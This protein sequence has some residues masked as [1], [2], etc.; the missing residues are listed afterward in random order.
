MSIKHYNLP[1]RKPLKSTDLN[2]L[3]NNGNELAETTSSGNEFQTVTIRT[4][5]KC[6]LQFTLES[7]KN[8]LK[9][10]PRVARLWSYEQLWKIIGRQQKRDRGK[11][12]ILFIYIFMSS[13]CVFLSF[14]FPSLFLFYLFSLIFQFLF[15]KLN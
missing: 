9:L 3:V 8:N 7:G 13:S 12:Y 14:L 1:I 4:A 11:F 10:C 6:C 15:D 2:R 5:K